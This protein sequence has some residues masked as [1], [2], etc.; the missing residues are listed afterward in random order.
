M[1]VVM[2]PSDRISVMHQGRLLAEGTPTEIAK[3]P[4]VQSAY[5]GELYG[6]FSEII[7]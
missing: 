6:D 4:A 2:S 7:T 1:G 3:N 5:L